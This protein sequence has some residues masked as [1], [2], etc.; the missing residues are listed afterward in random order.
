MC[1]LCSEIYTK[2]KIDHWIAESSHNSD[3]PRS[4]IYKGAINNYLYS[5]DED[6]DGDIKITLIH[7]CPVCRR[8]LTYVG[9]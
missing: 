9:G 5:N 3:I 6:Y 8:E 4:V 7:Y 2:D 1:Q